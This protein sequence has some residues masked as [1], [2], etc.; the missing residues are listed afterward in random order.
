MKI[1][2]S[3]SEQPQ[4]KRLSVSPTDGHA[5]G[6]PPCLSVPEGSGRIV[7]LSLD[8]QGSPGARRRGGFRPTAAK[9]V[10]AAQRGAGRLWPAVKRTDH[11]SG[12]VSAAPL[13]PGAGVRTPTRALDP[14]GSWFVRQGGPQFTP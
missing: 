3:I 10:E 12:G 14:L 11:G 6:F 9:R 1:K 5:S 7:R 4:T 13:V 2:E 8:A